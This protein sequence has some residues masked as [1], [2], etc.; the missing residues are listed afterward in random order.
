MEGAKMA[1]E[2][3]SHLE[4][5]GSQA[6]SQQK[7]PVSRAVEIAIVKAYKSRSLVLAGKGL[8]EVPQELL[9]LSKLQL[10]DLNLSSNNI[11]ILPPSLCVHDKLN[12]FIVSR[13]RLR[14]LPEAVSCLQQLRTLDCSQNCIRGVPSSIAKLTALRSLLLMQ[15]ELLSLQENCF[16]SAME[17][18]VLLVGK[19]HLQALPRSM[20]E[21]QSLLY[22]TLSH[23]QIEDADSLFESLPS[24]VVELDL[25]HNKI[26]ILPASIGKLSGLSR[27]WLGKNQLSHVSDALGTLSSL[28]EVDLSFNH[29][30]ALPSAAAG[31]TLVT[32][33]V[34]S[35]NH[36][37]ALPQWIGKLTALLHLDLT[38]N[39]LRALPFELSA[40]SRLKVLSFHKNPLSHTFAP[41]VQMRSPAEVMNAMAV[42][43]FDSDP[44]VA[45]SGSVHPL[46]V[47]VATEEP[48]LLSASGPGRL[49]AA[50][51]KRA[52][53]AIA[54]TMTLSPRG[55][56]RGSAF[57][58]RWVSIEDRYLAFHAQAELFGQP[59]QYLSD[60]LLRNDLSEEALRHVH[61][62]AHKTLLAKAVASQ[63]QLATFPWNRG[64]LHEPSVEV[65][66]HRLC[67]REQQQ[68]KKGG[69]ASG[70]SAHAV[71]TAHCDSITVANTSQQETYHFSFHCAND[72]QN[73]GDASAEKEVKGGGS[74]RPFTFSISSYRFTLPP[75]ESTNVEFQ[76]MPLVTGSIKFLLWIDVLSMLLEDEHIL[77][78]RHFIGVDVVAEQK[79]RLPE[80][81]WS[82]V[83]GGEPVGVGGEATVTR[84][85]AKALLQDARMEAQLNGMGLVATDY[86]AVKTFH[87]AADALREMK[88][89]DLAC[90]QPIQAFFN[91]VGVLSACRHPNIVL[92]CGIC[93][94]PPHLCLVTEFFPHG[95]LQSVLLDRVKYPSLPAELRVKFALDVARAL[96]CLHNNNIVH[97]DIKAANCF[98]VCAELEGLGGVNVKVGDFGISKRLLCSEMCQEEKGGT[99]GTLFWMAPELFQKMPSLQSPVDVYSFGILLWEILSRQEDPYPTLRSMFNSDVIDSVTR[100]VRPNLDVV[101]IEVPPA[102]VSL[103]RHC[104]HATPE[105][106]PSATNLVELLV[107]WSKNVPAEYAGDG[108]YC[109]TPTIAKRQ[110]FFIAGHTPDPKAVQIMFQKMMEE[111]SEGEQWFNSTRRE[112]HDNVAQSC[113]NVS[114]CRHEDD[115][116]ENDDSERQLSGKLEGS[117]GEQDEASEDLSRKDVFAVIDSVEGGGAPESSKTSLLADSCQVTARCKSLEELSTSL[118]EPSLS[119]TTLINSQEMYTNK[120]LHRSQNAHTNASSPLTFRKLGEK[121]TLPR[122]DSHKTKAQQ[123]LVQELLSRTGKST[124]GS[125]LTP[126]DS[127]TTRKST[128]SLRETSSLLRNEGKETAASRQ[129]IPVVPVYGQVRESRSP[130]PP[131]SAQSPRRSPSRE[132]AEL[133]RRMLSSDL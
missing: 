58:G 119:R 9:C 82:M 7:S 13:N 40:L 106:R 5:V 102:L 28:R 60:Y 37:Q 118:Q 86:L 31:W 61:Q 52:S 75:G 36:L 71:I 90:M 94:Q 43:A 95:D 110:S 114:V 16:N 103:M 84:I 127:V 108:S 91:E 78:T 56:S 101:E 47:G 76:L 83:D 21:L 4:N 131:L 89:T 24:S 26:R 42:I 97:N 30:D 62:H 29:I 59:P 107:E 57:T 55:T 80:L 35:Y 50:G 34:V 2:G 6:V 11:K 63:K 79:V 39:S 14:S 33:L 96:E 98:I 65:S 66:K 19:N 99:G 72:L 74:I 105:N 115:G 53:H 81:D 67:F 54:E 100:G 68:G 17:L 27:L 18:E 125:K 73:G 25:S 122:N 117:S 10:H 45:Q 1:S 112:E 116:N 23:N 85:R 113:N 48:S 87:F 77:P 70:V 126:A 123:L 46:E 130:V 38:C 111:D 133:R 128:P 12:S 88:P 8:S 104:W 15:N 41:L 20:N 22:V 132:A 64:G 69:S 32:K 3:G 124:S 93:C 120:A 51:S 129:P 49:L 44:L 121:P 109:S 92:A